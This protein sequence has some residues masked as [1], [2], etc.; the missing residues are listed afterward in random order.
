MEIYEKKYGFSHEDAQTMVDI[1]FK[2]NVCISLCDAIN[3]DTLPISL[4]LLLVEFLY[5]SYDGRRIRAPCYR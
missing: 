4:F 5:F 1:S 3:Q 2:Y